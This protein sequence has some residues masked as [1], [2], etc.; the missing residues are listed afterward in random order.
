MKK[1]SKYFVSVDKKTRKLTVGDLH[2]MLK[3]DRKS[4]T[5]RVSR[6]GN[7]ISGSRPFWMKERR[8]LDAMVDELGP[9]SVFLTF[10][11]ADLQ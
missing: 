8:N 5:D 11:A 9:P 1:V 4:L 7:A 6:R 10:S 3:G 2:A